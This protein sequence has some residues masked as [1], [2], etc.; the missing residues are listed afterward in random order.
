MVI[1]NMDA[2]S[3][4]LVFIAYY[5]GIWVCYIKYLCLRIIKHST[6]M[7]RSNETSYSEYLAIW[8]YYYG[9]CC[10]PVVYLLA[11]TNWHNK[12]SQTQWLTTISICSKT[13]GGTGQLWFGWACFDLSWVDLLQD[14]KKAVRGFR[15]WVEFRSASWVFVLGPRIQ[16]Q[17]MP[18]A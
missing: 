8:Y 5:F 2:E 7:R 16:G 14:A 13:Q 9:C 17:Q 15:L 4:K 11:T 3:R 12:W 10:V 1:K 18:G 6:I